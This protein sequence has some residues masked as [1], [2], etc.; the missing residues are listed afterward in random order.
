AQIIT[1]G[2]LGAKAA[3]RD[4]GR[5]LAMSYGDVDRVAKMIPFKLNITLGEALT[6][7]PELKETYEAEADVKTLIDTAQGLEGLT[8]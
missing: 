2:T 7:S 5:A 8:R 4:V 6:T 1:F 3:V